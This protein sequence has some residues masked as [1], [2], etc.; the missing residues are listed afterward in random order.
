VARQIIT[1]VP[2]LEAVLSKL[3]DKAADRVARSAIGGGLTV[4][5]KRIRQAAP[6][7]KTGA[8]KKS[9]RSRFNR[10]QGSRP[11]S[12]KVGINVGKQKKTA[13]GLVKRIKDPLAHL[14]ALGTKRRKRKKLG[15]KFAFI[16]QPSSQQLS[17]GTM[18]ENP[19]LR[20]AFEAA[21]P[22]TMQRMRDRAAKALEREAAKARK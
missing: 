5:A 6:K 14:V 1:G 15:G 11:V 9:I 18:P 10:K 22:E 12:A 19:F 4:A 16:K 17:T 8:F 20:K 2:E 7:G 13:E 21:R 3:A